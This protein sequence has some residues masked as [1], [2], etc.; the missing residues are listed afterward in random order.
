MEEA[1]E[2]GKESSHSAHAN[3]MN[4]F[5]DWVGCYPM[6]ITS[7]TVI[8]LF[9]VCVCIVIFPQLLCI[10]SRPQKFIA[11]NGT[12]RLSQNVSKELPLYAA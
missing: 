9:F 3:G 4:E 8:P 11:E 1:S 7:I 12:D 2:N 6:G 5:S 10:S